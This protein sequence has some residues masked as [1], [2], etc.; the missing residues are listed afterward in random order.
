MLTLFNIIVLHHL[1]P[2]QAP[3]R[4]QS[5]LAA[6]QLV[7]AGWMPHKLL[8]P[9]YHI[10]LLSGV[11]AIDVTGNASLAGPAGGASTVASSHRLPHHGAEVLTMRSVPHAN[12]WFVHLPVQLAIW[13]QPLHCR[14]F[15]SSH[16]IPLPSCLAAR[17]KPSHQ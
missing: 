8:F 14:H 10:W 6:Y 11:A 17:N 5:L 2:R 12:P 16:G 4:P 15:Q 9:I 3:Q 1:T 13:L 7:F